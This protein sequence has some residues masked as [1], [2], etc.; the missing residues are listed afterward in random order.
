MRILVVDDN[1]VNRMQ[2]KSLLAQYGDCDGAGTADTAMQLFVDAHKEEKPYNLI[3]MDIELGEADG[4]DVVKRLRKWES[5]NEVYK[6][7]KEARILMVTVKDSGR[8]V[9]ASFHQGCEGYLV[10][11]VSSESLNMELHRLGILH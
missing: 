10:K 5:E 4:R 6:D 3:T 11:P 7:G 1:Y 2:L 9:F 8:D